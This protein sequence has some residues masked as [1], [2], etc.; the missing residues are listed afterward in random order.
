MSLVKIPH[1]CPSL[2][3]ISDM[4]PGS[5]PLQNRLDKNEWVCREEMSQ[6]AAERNWQSVNSLVFLLRALWYE[7]RLIFYISATA[8]M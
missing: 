3:L 8:E 7:S 1:T 5:I 6:R 4:K 2:N